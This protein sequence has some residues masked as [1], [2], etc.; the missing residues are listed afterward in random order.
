MELIE[1]N[2]KTRT[3]TGNGPA[4]VL[5]REGR[6]P[7]VLYGPKTEPVKLSV[8]IHELELAF[9]K[10]AATQ[11]LINLVVHDSDTYTKSVMVKEL[12]T[13][14]TTEA[15]LHADFYEIDLSRKI[16]V[17]VPILPVGKSK[18]VEEGGLLQSIR[19][20]LEI[21]C[22]PNQIPEAIEVDVTDLAIGDSLHVKSIPLPEG[23]EVQTETDFTVLT[24]VTA[25]VEV[26]AE[27]AEDELLEGEE[28]EA[29]EGEGDGEAAGEA[30]KEADAD[31]AS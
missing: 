7:A 25:K 20:E 17:S 22:F 18:G 4:R 24:V 2:A 14:P 3:T 1:I 5:R 15:L 12:Q 13:H 16:S 8:E 29:V 26:E 21:V 23:V 19:R 11:A 6:I 10:T 28:L 9:K 27:V 30:S 31:D